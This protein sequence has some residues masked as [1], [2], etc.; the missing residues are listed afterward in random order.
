MMFRMSTMIPARKVWAGG[1]AGVAAAVIASLL[2]QYADVD[3]SA[4]LIGYIIAGIVP[5]VAYLVPPSARDAIVK[6]DEVARQVG[7]APL[8]P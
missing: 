2:R 8:E 5:S 4:D 1:L 7:K 6:A 3:V